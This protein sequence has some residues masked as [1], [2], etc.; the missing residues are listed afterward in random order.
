MIEPTE[1]EPKAEL[2]R[3][4]DALISIRAEVERVEMGLA[5]REDNVLKGAPHTALEVSADSWDHVYSREEAAYPAPWSRAH[6]FWPFVG[7]VDNAFGD[8]NLVC[9]CPPVSAYA[10]EEGAPTG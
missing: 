6:K 8:R 4:V 9:V 5:D 2:D 3:F 10:E 1:S 7:R